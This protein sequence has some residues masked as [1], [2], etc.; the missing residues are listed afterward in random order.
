MFIILESVYTNLSATYERTC[1]CFYS[2]ATAGQLYIVSSHVGP[3]VLTVGF[4][5]PRRASDVREWLV[6]LIEPSEG[7]FWGDYSFN[8]DF[9]LLLTTRD[10]GTFIDFRAS[11]NVNIPGLSVMAA[12]GVNN[13]FKRSIKFVF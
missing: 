4:M 5:T 11:I 3:F 9:I 12:E 7:K 2:V 1:E 10:S 6:N 13:E 8:I